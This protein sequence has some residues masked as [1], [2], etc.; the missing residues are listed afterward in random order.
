MSETDWVFACACCARGR[1]HEHA[2]Y[3]AAC[4]APVL[5]VP[6]TIGESDLSASGPGIWRYRAHLPLAGELAWL[7]MGESATPLVPAPRLAD[8]VGAKEIH[9]LL[10]SLNPTGS[11]KDRSV[12]AGIAHAVE[13]GSNG[14]ICAS[15]GNAAGSVA[16]YAGRAGLPAI[17]LVPES[18]PPAKISL[19][20]AFGAHALKVAGDYSAAFGLARQLSRDL[21][22]RNLAT[23]YVNPVAVAALRTV[24]FDIACQLDRPVDRVLVPTGAGPL[25]HGVAEGFRYLESRAEL[26]TLPR[27]DAVQP[28]GCAPI[29]RAFESG[30]TRVRPWGDVTSQISGLGDPLRGYPDDGTVTLNAVRSTAGTAIAVPDEAA[31]SA[32]RLLATEHG[33]FVEPAAATAVAG[34]F[35]LA[36][37][38]RVAADDTIVCLLT[39][40]GLKTLSPDDEPDPPLV[41]DTASALAHLR[42]VV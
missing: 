6:R 3:C 37:E 2:D 22:M 7:S 17:I 11:F 4:G 40:H 20:R 24:A 26:A 39:G 21:G 36:D 16:A 42:I 30:E 5:A 18:T 27:V 8:R 19:A 14:V 25:V 1:S 23:T 15:S 32:Q 29:V 31:L 9:F 34:L 41:T 33:I 38:G 13:T 35:K 10:E 12:T 28:V